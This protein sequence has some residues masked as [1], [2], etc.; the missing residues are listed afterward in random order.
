VEYG[1]VN[2]SRPNKSETNVGATCATVEPLINTK[3]LFINC[4][5]SIADDMTASVLVIIVAIYKIT[6]H[7]FSI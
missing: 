3:K 4:L 1:I 5:L 2:G 7:F 6:I